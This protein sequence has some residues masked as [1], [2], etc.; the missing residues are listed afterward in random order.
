MIRPLDDRIFIKR[1]ETKDVT[2]GGIIIP[3][4][5]EQIPMEGIIVAAG[6]GKYKDGERVPLVV[7]VGDRVLFASWASKDVEIDGETYSVMKEKDIIG[8]LK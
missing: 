5:V 2:D 6:P 4:N 7:K 8:L 3:E 1:V